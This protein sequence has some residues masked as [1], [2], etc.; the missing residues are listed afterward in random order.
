MMT[1]EDDP[2]NDLKEFLIISNDNTDLLQLSHADSNSSHY[3]KEKLWEDLRRQV[4]GSVV[5]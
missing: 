3:I 4:L 1:P 2:Q 5:S